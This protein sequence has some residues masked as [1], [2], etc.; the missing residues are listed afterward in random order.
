MA[1]NPADIT[2]QA[3]QLELLEAKL[4]IRLWETQQ[5]LK[6]LPH[7]PYRPTKEA[8]EYRNRPNKPTLPPPLYGGT[9]GLHAAA[10]EAASWDTTHRRGTIQ[11]KEAA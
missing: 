9:A 2:A 11:H 10:R 4:K 7:R 8:L 1:I 5:Q 3:E 6:K